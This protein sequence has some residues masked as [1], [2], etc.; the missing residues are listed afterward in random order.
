MRREL[1]DQVFA[2]I[3]AGLLA[4]TAVSG[5]PKPKGIHTLLHSR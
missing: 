5:G 1:R 4:D 3:K 2:E